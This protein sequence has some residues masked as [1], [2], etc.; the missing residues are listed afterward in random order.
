MSLLTALE[1]RS[2]YGPP[3]QERGMVLWVIPKDLQI[4]AVPARIYCNRQLREPL[5]QA[6][7]C[8]EEKGLS[9]HI[10][11]W[12]GCFNIRKTF[13]G[14]T[15]SLHSWGLAVDLNAGWNR[16]AMKPTM[17]P[18]VVDCFVSA[19]FDWGGHFRVPDGMHFQLS[20]EAF[21]GA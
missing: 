3:E 10:K 1:A 2:K 20:R 7:R 8:I 19:G 18:D 11:T 12:D 13:A 21:N 5:E 17:N 9:E 6:L 4:G 14:T 16:Y 15:P